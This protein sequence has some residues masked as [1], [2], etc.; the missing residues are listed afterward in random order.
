M[1]R[2]S[3]NHVHLAPADWGGL[4]SLG[5]AIIS[6][7]GATLWQ[8]H[9]LAATSRE[10]LARFEVEISNLKSDVTLLKTDYRLLLRG[11]DQP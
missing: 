2:T 7:V 5:L 9:D 3:E 6:L 1:V 10:R 11:G 4:L 8:V